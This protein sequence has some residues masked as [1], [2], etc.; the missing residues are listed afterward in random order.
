MIDDILDTENVDY[1]H[2][3]VNTGGG[4]IL[5][6]IQEPKRELTTDNYYTAVR[7]IT[8]FMTDTVI[9]GTLQGEHFYA[10]VLSGCSL[11]KCCPN[12]EV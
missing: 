9:Q 5:Y 10:I 2:Y 3:H 8:K 1:L 12:P 7:F 4:H 6:D 11:R